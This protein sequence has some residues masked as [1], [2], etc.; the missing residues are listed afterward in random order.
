MNVLQQCHCGTSVFVTA[1]FPQFS[2]TC[3]VW[4]R[5][6]LLSRLSLFISLVSPTHFG[7]RLLTT[8][9]SFFRAPSSP[10]SLEYKISSKMWSDG[11]K[12]SFDWTS[13]FVSI[14]ENLKSLLWKK[15]KQLSRKQKNK[16]KY[17]SDLS[18]WRTLSS[19]CWVLLS[20]RHPRECVK[21]LL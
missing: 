1:C 4:F 8:S 9:S 16:S 2:S 14:N 12:K 6:F 13:S 5:A 19:L 18:V 20:S 15:W 17:K 21:R 7:R 10:T 11:E 3:R